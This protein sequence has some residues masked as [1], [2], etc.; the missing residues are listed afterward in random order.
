MS[1]LDKAIEVCKELSVF[2]R[3]NLPTDVN[4]NALD[5]VLSTIEQLRTEL[6][7]KDKQIEI[8]KSNHAILGTQ[9]EID[10]IN[11]MYKKDKEIQELKAKVDKYDKLKENLELSLECNPFSSMDTRELLKEME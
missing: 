2:L 9:K 7:N 10:L 11:E 4:S 6:D 1:E 3:Q 8:L 5:K